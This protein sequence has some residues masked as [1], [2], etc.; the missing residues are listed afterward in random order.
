MKEK[1]KDSIC[2]RCGKP[3]FW[4]R[5]IDSN[6][7]WCAEAFCDSCGTGHIK[8]V[9]VVDRRIELQEEQ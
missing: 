4:E 1:I 9:T 6:N 8:Y 2:E 3:L 5:H 7:N